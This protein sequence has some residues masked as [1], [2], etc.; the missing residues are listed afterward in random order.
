MIEL[1]D[2][3]TRLYEK[4]GTYKRMK[5]SD[6]PSFLQFP[7]AWQKIART[8]LKWREAYLQYWQETDDEDYENIEGD[9]FCNGEWHF[10][11]RER[12]DDPVSCLECSCA[13]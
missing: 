13:D 8:E 3:L 2:E 9:W 7:N 1:W 10:L 12:D 6:S 11:F 4:V 5:T